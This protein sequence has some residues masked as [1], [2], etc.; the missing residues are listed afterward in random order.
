MGPFLEVDHRRR[1]KYRGK[2]GIPVRAGAGVKRIHTKYKALGVL[3]TQRWLRIW[4]GG[5]LPEE[6]VPG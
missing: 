2:S 5:W 1:N 6:K 4:E 3:G